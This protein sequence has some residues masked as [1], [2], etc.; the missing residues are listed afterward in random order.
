MSLNDYRL[1]LL[2]VADLYICKYVYDV[3][4]GKMFSNVINTLLEREVNRW[5]KISSFI[6]STTLRCCHNGLCG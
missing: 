6:T 4:V 3:P 1:S 5:D 2:A